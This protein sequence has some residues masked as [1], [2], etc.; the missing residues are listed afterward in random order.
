MDKCMS[1]RLL[2]TMLARA[3]LLVRFRVDVLNFAFS[4][5]VEATLKLDVLQ[6]VPPVCRSHSRICVLGRLL[7]TVRLETLFLL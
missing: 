3:S 4:L 7:A 2:S 5:K 1:L 6:L